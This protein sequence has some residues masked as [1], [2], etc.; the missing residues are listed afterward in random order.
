MVQTQLS[1]ERL[2]LMKQTVKWI[3]FKSSYILFYFS[4]I[5]FF[6]LVM[7]ASSIL[8]IIARFRL[9]MFG[10]SNVFLTSPVAPVFSVD[11]LTYL[12][13]S[14][15]WKSVSFSI[16]SVKNLFWI[17]NSQRFTTIIRVMLNLSS[18]Y[19]SE[20]P[21]ST[22][23]FSLCGC[24]VATNMWTSLYVCIHPKQ[25]EENML[26]IFT[27][28]NRATMYLFVEHIYATCVFACWG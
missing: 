15:A 19:I 23:W 28:L 22:K 9:A 26:Y 7:L 1:T 6:N 4:V 12:L 14:R 8:V 11:H 17:M 5:H 10:S 27:P 18:A 13:A 2:C 21:H 25:Y 20:D 24:N 16:H 3:V